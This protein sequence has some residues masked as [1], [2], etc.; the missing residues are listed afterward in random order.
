MSHLLNDNVRTQVLDLC[1]T[2]R[3]LLSESKISAYWGAITQLL[4][5]LVFEVKLR[6]WSWLIIL[7]ANQFAAVD[8]LLNVTPLK[9]YVTSAN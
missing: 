9:L 4:Q 6:H 1:E 5:A 3:K 2:E 8:T 7:D